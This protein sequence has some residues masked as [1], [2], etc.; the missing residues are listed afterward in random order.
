MSDPVQ[1]LGKKLDDVID[2]LESMTAGITALINAIQKTNEWLGENVKLLT[3]TIEGYT[4]TMTQ[5]LEQ[6]FE[7]SRDQI[8]AVSG[9]ITS[10]TRVTGTDQIMRINQAL[11]SILSLLQQAIDPNRIQVQLGEIAQFIKMHGGQT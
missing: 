3:A 7:Q 8:L 6:D 10:L 2:R 9:A 1:V 11:T 4:D 5:R